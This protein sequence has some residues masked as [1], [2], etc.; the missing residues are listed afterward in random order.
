MSVFQIKKDGAFQEPEAVKRKENGAWIEAESA[1]R[2]VDGAWQ[3]VW[4]NAL[5]L[6]MIENTIT[7]GASSNGDFED[8]FK[9]ITDQESAAGS[10]TYVAEGSFYNPTLSFL[11]EIWFAYNDMILSGGDVY[12]YGVKADGTV[13]EVRVVESAQAETLTQ[14]TY[15]FTGGSYKKIGFKYRSASWGVKPN[16]IWANICNFTIDGKKCVFNPDDNFNFN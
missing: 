7:T 9:W 2:L 8:G 1:K 5:E 13:D 6:R 4:T 16:C 14:A 15:S 3:D 10:V 11:Y 12:A